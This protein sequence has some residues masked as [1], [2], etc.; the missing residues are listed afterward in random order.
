MFLKKKIY[1]II[2]LCFLTET[3]AIAQ[4]VY[5]VVINVLQLAAYE[6]NHPELL[7]ACAT[8]PEKEKDGGWKGLIDMPL[9]KNAVIKKQSIEYL[10][11]GAASNNFPPNKPETISPSP[12][13]TFLGQIDLG[14]TIPP[15]TH[16][17]I[18]PNHVVTVTNEIMRI[19]SKTGGIISTIGINTFSGVQ[20]TCDPYI[21]YDPA[22][23][24]WFYVAI[25]CSALNDNKVALL[26]S[27]S[28]NP[29]GNWLRYSFVPNLPGGG[30]FLDHPYLGFDN[31]WLV[32]SGRKFSDASVFTGPVLFLFE[33][34]NLVDNG[35]L[36]FGTNA[37]A[38]EKNIADGDAPLPVTLSGTNPNINTF[39]VLQNWNA[40]TSSIR[41]S[42]ITGNIPNAS[43]NTSDAVFPSGGSSYVSNTGDIAEQIGETRKLS[44]NDARISSGVMVNGKIWCA[45]HIGISSTN[46]AI[47][48]WQLNGLAGNNFGD[49]LQRGRIGD[50]IANNYRWFPSIAVNKSD[51][52]IIGYT[53][54]SNTSLVSSA[55]SI[56]T[57]LTPLNTMLDENIYKVGLSTYYKT[58]GTTRARWGDY[59][60]SAVDPVDE[61]LW[62]IQEY[63]DQR[64]GTTDNDSKFGVWWAQVLP[65]SALLKRNAGIG[66]IIEPLGELQCS[67]NITPKITIQNFGTDTLKNVE[68]G[69]LLDGALFGAA[70]VLNNLSLPTF[71]VSP[72][73]SLTP[74]FEPTGG[75]HQL[76]IYTK[77]PNGSPDQNTGN[78]TA[79]VAFE[80]APTLNLPYTESFEPANFPP[81]NG[82]A[83]INENS[84]STTWTRFSL[85]GNPGNACIRLN[86]FSY[87]EVGQRDI[88]RAPK[89]NAGILD[90]LIVNFNVA[91][92]THS[93]SADSLLVVYSLDCGKTWLRTNYAKG[94]QLLSTSSG[95]TATS[96]IP[97]ASE[98]RAESMVLKDFCLKKSESIMIGFQSYNDFGNNIYVDGINITG[99]VSP[100]RNVLLNSI[101]SPQFALCTNS[102]KPTVGFSNVG[103]DTIRSLKLNYQ[104][105]GGA[106]TTLNWTGSLPKCSSAFETLAV[107]N[108]STGTHI[109]TVFT[110]E[111]NGLIDLVTAGD[112]LR[113]TFT[114]YN[115]V[116]IATPV[117][118]G[119]ETTVIPRV[120]WGIQNLDGLKTWQR[121]TQTAR[122][123]AASLLINNPAIENKLNAIDHFISPIVANNATIDSMFVSWDYSYKTGPGFPGSALLP[124]DTLEVSITRD[125]GLTFIPVW[126][127]WGADLQTVKDTTNTNA[128]PF[129]PDMESEWKSARV[130]LST[131]VGADIF[132]VYFTSKSNK[133]NNLW[134]DNVNISSK[135]LPE[136]L[137][138][139]GYLIYPNPFQHSFLIHHFSAPVEL[140]VVQLYNAAGQLIWSNR[141]FANATTEINMNMGNLAKGLYILK[142]IYF[143]KTVVERIIKN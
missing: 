15:D 62:T 60:H 121:T 134:L 18:G 54:S 1:L 51:D 123:G 133:Q 135:T 74:A 20:N 55:Y 69:M 102:F 90:S 98:W 47:Q 132:Q 41:L 96:F 87:R 78:D 6:K 2:C 45:Q 94:G 138:N 119:F 114:I 137:R 24:R 57:N 103:T 140:Q 50:G 46:V 73:I 141:Y 93:G 59:S 70:T 82:S 30:F 53:V 101:N 23:Q 4:T 75:K 81:A 48:W 136:R 68:V 131:I 86:A 22:S 79:T 12:N 80:F 126:K 37:Q 143:N 44:T 25:D 107:A 130:Y 61:S 97:T 129:V 77:N 85:A 142:M 108:T 14:Q 43:W 92:K 33:K 106:I 56:R 29:T 104:I 100:S 26:V 32:I 27:A 58:F 72:V 118:E 31:R 19:H 8:C 95:S 111:P 88:Y 35:T 122:S 116:P 36:I 76:T 39:Y 65:S 9:P 67:S 112:T 21:L 52:V 40:A 13:K 117:A 28:N 7:K 128:P 83:V 3:V 10:K 66:S 124:A 89:I 109:L 42:T 105:D 115:T 120:N 11:P 127:K 64:V 71:D 49:I 38:I 113:K 63:A 125:C 110:S 91:Y 16:G 5:P 99:F 34:T 84:G 139:Q 17:A